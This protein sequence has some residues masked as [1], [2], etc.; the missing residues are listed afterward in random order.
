MTPNQ[1]FTPSPLH[2][3]R[4][5]MFVNRILHQLAITCDIS[6]VIAS[7]WISSYVGLVAN[8]NVDSIAKVAYALNI[9]DVPAIPS[10]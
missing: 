1:R 10:L 8:D 3:Q 9:P 5:S 7:L 4:A 6:L 2:D